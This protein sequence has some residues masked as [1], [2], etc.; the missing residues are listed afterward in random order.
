MA[1]Q[2]DA[3]RCPQVLVSSLLAVYRTAW[4]PAR[5]GGGGGAPDIAQLHR[6]GLGARQ[7]GSQKRDEMLSEV[8]QVE[9]NQR[10]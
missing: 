2:K 8:E 9:E 10:D 7:H 3:V 1:G 6:A 5:P 4:S